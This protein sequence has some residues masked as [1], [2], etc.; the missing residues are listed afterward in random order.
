MIFLNFCIKITSKGIAYDVENIFCGDRL[1]QTV[2]QKIF[3]WKNH[4]YKKE[5]LTPI[6][7]LIITE[8]EDSITIFLAASNRLEVSVLLSSTNF[9]Y[10]GLRYEKVPR[11]KSLK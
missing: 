3:H 9:L 1:T 8:G 6:G 10:V 4:C 11:L 2:Q 5:K 7:A